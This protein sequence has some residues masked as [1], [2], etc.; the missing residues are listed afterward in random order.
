MTHDPYYVIMG[1]LDW[2]YATRDCVIRTDRGE[3]PPELPCDLVTEYLDQ[4]VTK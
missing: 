1:F 4:R 3:I 2:L